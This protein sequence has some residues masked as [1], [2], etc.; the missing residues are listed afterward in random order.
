MAK[1][2]NN[3]PSGFD[4]IL[5]NIY[6]N[7]MSDDNAVTLIEDQN[8]IEQPLEDDNDKVPPV[9]KTEDGEKVDDSQAAHE[10][11]SEIP[12]DIKNPNSSISLH[13]ITTIVLNP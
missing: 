10:D 3:I 9:E 4:D 5:G 13:I 2:K 1:K 8:V 7:S 11:D 12:E 6:S